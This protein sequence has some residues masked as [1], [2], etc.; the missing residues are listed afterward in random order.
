MEITSPSLTPMTIT[1][2]NLHTQPPV[3]GTVYVHAFNILLQPTHQVNLKLR[4][5]RSRGSSVVGLASYR[6]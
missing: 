1:Y 5:A 6:I 4:D 3:F 2:A